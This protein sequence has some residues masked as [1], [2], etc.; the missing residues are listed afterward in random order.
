MVGSLTPETY[1]CL[2]SPNLSSFLQAVTKLTGKKKKA[3]TLSDSPAV[4]I[5]TAST[6]SDTEDFGTPNQT[7]S[8]S[9]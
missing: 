2:N 6:S 4:E 1:S 8:V 9:R 7:M 5:L 3:V